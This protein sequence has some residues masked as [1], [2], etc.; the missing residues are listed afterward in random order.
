[1]GDSFTPEKHGSRKV[2][3]QSVD[4]T[5]KGPDHLDEVW[6]FF[7]PKIGGGSGIR[8]HDEVAPI[9]VFEFDAG[10]LT[11]SRPVPNSPIS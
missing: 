8:T 4:I 10:R 5:E 3:G 1:M 11:L 7:T 2:R 9:P 6:A